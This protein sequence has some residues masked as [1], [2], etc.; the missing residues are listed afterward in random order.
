MGG[1]VGSYGSDL[2]KS[3][4]RNWADNTFTGRAFSG[5]MRGLGVKGFAAGGLAK[6]AKKSSPKKKR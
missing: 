3:F 1:K 4:G 2:S 6:K 5:A